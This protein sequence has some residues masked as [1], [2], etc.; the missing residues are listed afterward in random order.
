MP[1]KPPKKPIDSAAKKE[2]NKDKHDWE[3]LESI[4]NEIKGLDRLFSNK[5]R[6][7]ELPPEEFKR[8][9][10]KH[11][12]L[13]RKRDS[14]KEYDEYFNTEPAP[15]MEKNI[16]IKKPVTPKDQLKIP[17]GMENFNEEKVEIGPFENI[18]KSPDALPHTAQWTGG[19]EVLNK[20]NEEEKQEPPEFYKNFLN[21]K[22]KLDEIKKP[23]AE[24]GP[25]E[26][27]ERLMNNAEEKA[28]SAQ[29]MPRP[30]SM[31]QVINEV[32]PQLNN[33]SASSAPIEPP[34]L[35]HEEPQPVANQQTPEQGN[36]IRV[37]VEGINEPRQERN[38]PPTPEVVNVVNPENNPVMEQ[39]RNLSMEDRRRARTEQALREI[40]EADIRKLIFQISSKNMNATEVPPDFEIGNHQDIINS[41]ALFL[42]DKKAFNDQCSKMKALS[43]KTEAEKTAKNEARIWRE[44]YDKS[45]G[46]SL[47][48][49]KLSLHEKF[50]NEKG[51]MLR[52]TGN[53]SDEEIREMLKKESLEYDARVIFRLA[54]PLET[55][56]CKSR[57]ESELSEK[58][59][60]L[61]QK[62]LAKYRELPQWKRLGISVALS[63]GIGAGVVF[64]GTGAI[65]AAATVGVARAGRTLAGGSLSA[66][67]RGVSEFVLGKKYNKK[68]EAEL[69][70]G[71]L[72]TLRKLEAQTTAWEQAGQEWEQS[73]EKKLKL[74]R[75]VDESA[76]DTNTKLAVISAKENKSKRIATIVSGLIGGGTVLGLSTDWD[77]LLSGSGTGEVGKHLVPPNAPGSHIEDLAVA[78]KGDS[79]WTLI[80]EN[81]TKIKGFNEL[82]EA[83]KTYFIDH[84]KDQV[85]ADP[86]K[87]G[88][89]NADQIK[90]GYGKELGQLFENNQDIQ[91]TLESA[92]HLTKGQ[93]DSIMHSNAAQRAALFESM[94]PKIP[95]EATGVETNASANADIVEVDGTEVGGKVTLNKVIEGVDPYGV[96][97]QTEIPAELMQDKE[98][99][100]SYMNYKGNPNFVAGSQTQEWAQ[101]NGAENLVKLTEQHPEYLKIEAVRNALREIHTNN[102]IEE[103]H[104]GGAFKFINSADHADLLNE[105]KGLARTYGFDSYRADSFADYVS[106]TNEMN[107]ETFTPFID[108]TSGSFLSDKFYESAQHFNDLAKSVTPPEIPEGATSSIWE[109]RLL[110]PANGGE[111]IIGLVRQA[112][113][114]M[115][116]LKIPTGTVSSGLS[117]D[118]IEKMIVKPPSVQK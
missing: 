99:A 28:D 91:S 29:E 55:E 59:M 98:L 80:D 14:L 25:G 10:E 64:A 108:N 22:T 37:T 115:F 116:E 110:S 100:Q 82:N 61:W 63:A 3:S 9:S 79:V 50:V 5:K 78:H 33:E 76:I 6:V 54:G 109:P 105:V 21:E 19:V 83:Q 85:A 47:D 86:Q 8:L 51:E 32:Y 60:K 112:S 114:N 107:E 23:E 102:L 20:K 96:K 11:I 57:A 45:L 15:Y 104:E 26:F 52:N 41:A 1:E 48:R 92:K 90:I 97:T 68:R 40:P 46:R 39:Q 65:A 24:T 27:V 12:E 103:L 58:D 87:F 18:D 77:A 30:Q 84:L 72:E 17:K 36:R 88:L 16:D 95:T 53:F 113:P 2:K 62:G 49:L 4:E 118:T 34:V 111:P 81:A 73:E 94:K 101:Q 69:S 38:Q 7:S 67:L 89:E 117:Y 70:A 35:L 75:I 71:E 106:Q 74:M 31:S 93:M 43:N 42:L 13:K 66:A 44:N 56:I